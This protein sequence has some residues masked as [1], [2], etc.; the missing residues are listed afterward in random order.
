MRRMRFLSKM[1]KEKCPIELVLLTA[2]YR[3]TLSQKIGL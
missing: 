1:I 2:S 3:L